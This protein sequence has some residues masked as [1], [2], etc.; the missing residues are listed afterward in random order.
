MKTLIDLSAMKGI[1]V[2]PGARIARA[3]GGVLTAP[4]IAERGIADRGI[5]SAAESR[6]MWTGR[7]SQVLAEAKG[8]A[9]HLQGN[10]RC[11]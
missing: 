8:D 6:R 9:A 11:G 2:D 7:A 10:V 5:T 4:V 1:R 3:E